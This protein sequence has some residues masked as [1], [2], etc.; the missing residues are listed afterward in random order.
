MTNWALYAEQRDEWKARAEKAEADTQKAL[1]AYS[2][3]RNDLAFKELEIRKLKAEVERLRSLVKEA[4]I[5]GYDDCY[6]QANEGKEPE[7][8]FQFAPLTAWE[9]SE[10]KK[11]QQ[12]EDGE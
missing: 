2:K 4:F 1:D 8:C 10:S 9:E 5:E 3:A 12:Q 7:E 6:M 11:A